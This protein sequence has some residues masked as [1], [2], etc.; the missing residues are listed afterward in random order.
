MIIADKNHDWLV[1]ERNHEVARL[2]AI[3]DNPQATEEEKRV[4][5]DMI[6]MYKPRQVGEF[7]P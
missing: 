6:Q 3:L 4:A 5:N 7:K 1:E 2:Q